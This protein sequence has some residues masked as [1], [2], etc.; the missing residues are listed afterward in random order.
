MLR[1]CVAVCTNAGA[2]HKR[3]HRYRGA[4][5]PF[6]T[7]GLLPFLIVPSLYVVYHF[8]QKMVPLCCPALAENSTN[9]LLLLIGL[10][11]S[12]F[13]SVS[14]GDALDGS[15]GLVSQVFSI[16][17]KFFSFQSAWCLSSAYLQFE[18]KHL[19]SMQQLLR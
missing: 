3:R 17:S 14:G 19:R 8:S 4:R 13:C 5:T 18:S 6:I 2:D 12:W 9:V 10:T 11:S 15:Y 1:K 16:V 7:V